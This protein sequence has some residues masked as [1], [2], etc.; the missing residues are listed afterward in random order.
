MDKQSLEIR[1]TEN[2]VSDYNRIINYLIENWPGRVVTNFEGM[3]QK[4]L[5]LLSSNC[6]M[7]NESKRIINVHSML[8]TKHNRLYYRVKNNFI[9][10]LNILDTRQNPANN[11]Y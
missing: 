2:A 9:E 1:W 4:K 8:L 7:G 10:L 6:F 5:K 3:V 11:P